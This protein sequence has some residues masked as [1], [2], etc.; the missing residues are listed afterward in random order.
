MRACFLDFQKSCIFYI[1]SSY[2]SDNKLPCTG[3]PWLCRKQI[4]GNNLCSNQC[5][6]PKI[7]KYWNSLMSHG[8]FC[9]YKNSRVSIHDLIRFWFWRVLQGRSRPLAVAA[10]KARGRLSLGFPETGETA[11]KNRA[12]SFNINS[13]GGGSGSIDS[14]P[15]NIG[16]LD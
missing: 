14:G 7:L 5:M 6:S 16:K 12:L 1:Q 11:R 10:G 15:S 4:R 3:Y 8:N 9:E 13:N 2:E